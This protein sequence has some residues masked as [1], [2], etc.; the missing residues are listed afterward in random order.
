[1]KNE[2]SKE[3]MKS[4]SRENESVMSLN[5]SCL[6]G[7]QMQRKKSVKTYIHHQRQLKILKI[8]L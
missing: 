7:Q 1:M 5:I 4:K 2:R 8:M 3:E 6:Q